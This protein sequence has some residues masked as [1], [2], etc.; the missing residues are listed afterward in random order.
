MM[1]EK[2]VERQEIEIK[3][4]M[5]SREESACVYRKQNT[6]SEKKDLSFS[7]FKRRERA[8]SK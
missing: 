1:M 4:L 8:L 6:I 5:V 2:R 7:S 3:P